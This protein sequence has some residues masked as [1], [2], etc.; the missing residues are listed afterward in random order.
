[1]KPAGTRRLGICRASLRHHKRTPSAFE[2]GTCQHGPVATAIKERGY[3]SKGI[4]SKPYTE[5]LPSRGVRSTQISLDKIAAGACRMASLSESPERL[6]QRLFKNDLPPSRSTSD[7][8]LPSGASSVPDRPVWLQKTS[9]VAPGARSR[10]WSMGSSFDQR[11][12]GHF[13]RRDPG[14]GWAKRQAVGNVRVQPQRT[15]RH[16]MGGLAHRLRSVWVASRPP[17]R[18]PSRVKKARGARPWRST[19]DQRRKSG[20]I[21]EPPCGLEDTA[22]VDSRD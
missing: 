15:G 3:F 21:L 19:S 6:F 7:F 10:T 2:R 13:Q 12:R 8:C 4:L 1:M 11:P 18:V 17:N 20:L 16:C 9:S 14:K 5:T 22:Q